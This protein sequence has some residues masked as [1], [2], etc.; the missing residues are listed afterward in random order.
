M[1]SHTYYIDLDGGFL[2]SDIV[3][4]RKKAIDYLWENRNVSFVVVYS[5]AMKRREIGRV[6][7]TASWPIFLWKPVRGH[8]ASL[9]KDGHTRRRK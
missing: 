2:D 7:Y 1:P 9:R 6:I 5:N 4:V 3:N 8:S